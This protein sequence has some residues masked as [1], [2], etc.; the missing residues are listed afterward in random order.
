[1][2]DRDYYEVLGVARDADAT[3]LKSAYRKMAK[4]L[5]PDCDGGDEHKFKELNEAYGI[6]S[7]PEK[8]AAYDRFGKAAFQNGQAGNGGGDPFEA[9]NDVFGDVFGELF[10]Q[11]QRR[12]SGPQR[13]ADLR[14]DLEIT[15]EQA[16]AGANTRINVP[17]TL[18]CESCKGSGAA[19]G[20]KP[21]TC[22]G[23]GGAGQVRAQQ[24]FFTMTRTC[25][26][27]GGRG[28]TIKD[29]CK[30]CHG[31]G[32]VRQDRTLEVQIPAGVEEGTRIRLS[33]EGE[34]GPRGGP[35]GDLYIFLSIKPHDM[36][37]RD[38]PDLY[39][40]A[41]VPMTTA[42]LGGEIEIPT[43]EGGRA[44]VKV[45]E[46]AQT[47]RRL[48][49]TGKGMSRLRSRDRGD[50]H[51]ELFVEIPVRLSAKQ[52]K[53]L[54]ELQQTCC[55]RSQPESHGFLDRVKRMFDKEDRPD[56]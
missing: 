21:E 54:E 35:R 49:L 50:L 32:A 42:A 36:F 20:S 37:E 10:G 23:C 15:L 40:R 25:P 6:L 17:T 41:P 31:R 52:R 12:R 56:A 34:A 46:G 53:L 44:K 18:A 28:Q 8:R 16:F 30:P 19:A 29:P 33:A 2:S 5:H 3:V 26:Q 39:C 14:Y 11:S 9:F 1:M 13:G 55:E 43:I 48:R 7:D 27:C 22:A 38:G 51:V 45:P 24:G 4:Q 47:G